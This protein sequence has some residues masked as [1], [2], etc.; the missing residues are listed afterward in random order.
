MNVSLDRTT[1][2]DEKPQTEKLLERTLRLSERLAMASPPMKPFVRFSRW[3]KQTAFDDVTCARLYWDFDDLV[4]KKLLGLVYELASADALVNACVE[5]W[6]TNLEGLYQTQKGKLERAVHRGDK[7]LPRAGPRN[8]F[9]ADSMGPGGRLLYVG[10]GSGRQC[11]DFQGRGLWTVGID[12]FAPLVQ[13]AGGW[14]AHFG[15]PAL[16][17]C[18]DMME[19]GFAPS[20]FDGILLEFYG[21]LPL[22]SQT[23][24]LQ[25]SLARLLDPEGQGF[26]VA[27][28]KRYASYWFRMIRPYPQAMTK[29]LALQAPADFMFSEADGNEE[30]LVYGLYN[31]CHTVQSLSSELGHTFEVAEC[32]YERD[33]RYVMAVVKPEPK[34]GGY[35]SVP[36]DE[37][38]VDPK[39]TPE[40]LSRAENM[41]SQVE[42]MCEQLEAHTAEVAARFP[43]PGELVADDFIESFAGNV[44]AFGDLLVDVLGAE[45][46]VRA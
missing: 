3:G 30:R 26:I 36:Q 40:C 19:S 21:S 28:R 8:S 42:H 35:D 25:R 18:M 44:A 11:F 12:T 24:A 34:G 23:L 7:R 1:T 14:A 27:Q 17:A 31:R 29:W 9:I 37:P 16:F 43:A 15:L 13:V 20:S 33:P 46:L 10:C 32:F 41:L 4:Q 2:A 45:S 5:Q 22:W 39:P 38:A 6:K